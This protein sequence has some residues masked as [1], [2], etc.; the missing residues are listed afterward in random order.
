MENILYLLVGLVAGGAG[1]FVASFVSGKKR[2]AAL[3]GAVEQVQQEVDETRRRASAELEQERAKTETLRQ[4]LAEIQ[5]KLK[6]QGRRPTAQQQQETQALLDNLKKSESARHSA[7]KGAEAY[8]KA[9]QEAEKRFQQTHA[10]AEKIQQRA[11]QLEAALQKKDQDLMAVSAGGGPKA[12]ADALA[13]K[14]YSKMGSDMNRVLKEL[15]DKEQLQVAVLADANGIVIAAAGDK[16]L[17]E[18]MAATAKMMESLSLQLV[19][20][21][22]FSKVRTFSLKDDESVVITGCAFECAG[23]TLGIATYGSRPPQDVML[24]ATMKHLTA[25]LS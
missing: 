12:N 5:S 13:A 6:A 17:K 1:G 21:V 16:D 4:G 24:E 18:G 2:V 9:W 19:G 10:A 15:V 22:P 11:V 3:Q 14:L 8:K 7:V 25:V 23:E 20:M